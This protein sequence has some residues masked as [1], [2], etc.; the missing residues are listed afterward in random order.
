M[1]DSEF[2]GSEFPFGSLVILY[3]VLIWNI[4]VTDFRSLC[5]KTLYA[6]DDSQVYVIG[7]D[8]EFIFC[9]KYLVDN[10]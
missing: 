7:K 1:R 2:Y 3:A 4:A 10:F 8:T 5:T 9:Q 6:S